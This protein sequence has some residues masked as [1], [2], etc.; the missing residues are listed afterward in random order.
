MEDLLQLKDELTKEQRRLEKRLGEIED[1][2]DSISTVLGLIEKRRTR[3][4][5]RQIRLIP[6][7]KSNAYANMAFKEAILSLLSTDPEKKWQP[8]EITEALLNGGFETKSKNFGGT[9]RATLQNFRKEE[10]LESEK[11]KVGKMELWQYW[12]KPKESERPQFIS[13]RQR[14][15]IPD[16]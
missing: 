1:E 8:K 11:I 10:I 4:N 14:I 2:L 15:E 12:S 16:D 13:R 3:I 5:E 9:V 7:E 6:E